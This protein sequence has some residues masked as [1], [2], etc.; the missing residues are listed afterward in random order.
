VNQ[1]SQLYLVYV[2]RGHWVSMEIIDNLL[3]V[4]KLFN[5]LI[6]AIEVENIERTIGPFLRK[7]MVERQTFLNIE[8]FIPTQDKI[9]RARSIQ[10]RAREGFILLPAS[11][12]AEPAWLAGFEYEIRRFPKGATKDQ[13]DSFALIGLLLDKQVSLHDGERLKPKTL[14]QAHIDEIE[15]PFSYSAEDHLGTEAVDSQMF[16]DQIGEGEDPDRPRREMY[17]KDLD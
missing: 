10:G 3:N 2:R 8:G 9:A 5:P 1:K 17:Y 12:A 7:A 4:Q 16:W 15:R 14:A 11:G 13:V 6:W